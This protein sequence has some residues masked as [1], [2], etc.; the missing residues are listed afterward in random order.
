[1]SRNHGDFKMADTKP[2]PLPKVGGTAAGA[3]PLTQNVPL[4]KAATRY[5]PSPVKPRKKKLAFAHGV[6]AY[7]MGPRAFPGGCR[8]RLDDERHELFAQNLAK[9]MPQSKAYVAAGFENLEALS[10]ALDAEAAR[11][12]GESG[13]TDPSDS[14]CLLP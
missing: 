5:I 12:S 8:L 10:E 6:T 14:A 3:R 7:N 2:L 13:D 9:G 4:N 11:R 1:M